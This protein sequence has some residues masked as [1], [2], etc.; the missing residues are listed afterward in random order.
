MTEKL[1]E[2]EKQSK[3]RDLKIYSDKVDFSSNDYLGIAKANNSGSTG[4]RLISGNN[5]LIENL[6][7]KFSSFINQECSLLFHSGFQANLGLIPT[8]TPRGSTII[9]DELIHASLRDGIKLSNANSFSFKHNNLEHLKERL[10]LSKGLVFIIIE[11][12]YSMDGDSPNLVDLIKLSDQYSANVIV[13][14]AHALGIVGENGEGLV[15]HLKLSNKVL[16]TIYPLGKAL[17]SSGSFISGSRVLKKFLVNYCR[18]FIY[19]TA[20]SNTIVKEIST[21][22]DVLINYT[23]RNNIFKLKKY[24]LN[25]IDESVSVISGE[26]GAIVSVLIPDKLRLKKIEQSLLNEDFFVKAILHPTVAKGKERLRVCFHSYNT[27]N[28]IDRL[29]YIFNKFN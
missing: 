4:S 14:E 26:Y 23:E 9:Y 17:G 22:L 29:L 11:S 21:Q 25:K 19:S 24:F 27:D 7:V 6:E 15:H 13:D 3:L 18:S 20:P 28:E 5:V 2:R 10:E 8:I 12:V 16:A 1:I